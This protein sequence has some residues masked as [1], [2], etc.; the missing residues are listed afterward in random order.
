[1]AVAQQYCFSVDDYDTLRETIAV[2]SEPTLL[3]AHRD[4]GNALAAGDFLD[5]GQ[6]G[7][8]MRAAG[9]GTR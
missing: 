1:M 3:A 5:A 9:R 7:E 6:L 2:L 4:G 8:A